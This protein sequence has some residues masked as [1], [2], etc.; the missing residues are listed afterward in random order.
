MASERIT[1]VDIGTNSVKVAQFEKDT[2]IRLIELRIAD[3]PRESATQEIDEQ[4][5]VNTLKDVLEHR[6]KSTIISIPREL[7]TLRRLTN[8]PITASDEQVESMVET[9]AE[10]E[11]PFG[12]TEVVFDYY[13]LRRSENHVSVDLVAAKHED[14]AKYTQ[15]F[16][17]IGIT[18]VTILPSTYASSALA[19]LQA[20]NSGNKNMIMVV[21]IG[22]GRTDLCVLR[23][24]NIIF[25]RS[26]PIGGNNLTHRFETNAELTFQEAEERKQIVDLNG[27]SPLSEYA[28]EWA[29]ELVL[30]LNRSIQAAS[31]N[32]L[33]RETR[34]DEI[35]LCG[36]GS[37]ISGI[38]QYISEK[39]RIDLVEWNPIEAIPNI[40]LSSNVSEDMY[41]RFAVTLGLGVN[42]FNKY[43]NLN[44]VLPE[45]I[46]KKEQ[47]ERKRKTIRYVLAAAAIIVVIIASLSGWG[48]YRKNKLESVK[49]ELDEYSQ[50]KLHASNSL[51]KDL[52]IMDM[53]EEEVSVLDILKELTKKLPKRTDVALTSFKIDRLDELDKTSLT[54]NAEASSYENIS[55]LISSIG[56]SEIFIDVKPGQVTSTERDRKQVFQVQIKCGVASNALK[57]ISEAKEREMNQP[58]EEL[59]VAD[60]PEQSQ[61][62]RGNFSDG[63]PSR[64]DGE[65]SSRREGSMP[66]EFQNERQRESM[67]QMNKSEEIERQ[68]ETNISTTSSSITRRETEEFEPEIHVDEE[69]EEFEHSGEEVPEVEIQVEETPGLEIET[70]EE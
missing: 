55:R 66:P 53:M 46:R 57:I 22:A 2:E 52:I 30:E 42:A 64:R 62:T 49:Q 7:V 34:P 69:I 24:E 28:I 65:R 48:Q 5:I 11:L 45:I 17:S 54:L 63:R 4:T 23:S 3:Y 32:L 50:A 26:I 40:E 36:G 18:P 14:I 38:G 21:D 51:T 61:E 9:Q 33:D 15:I 6:T 31:R 8:F 67:S 29:D 20:A 70:G 19:M 43:I 41:N 27:G 68:K 58:G 16:E 37:K 1:T 47:A 59:A 39:L 10:T 35:W 25:N 60:N 56:N 44:L 13:N 12:T